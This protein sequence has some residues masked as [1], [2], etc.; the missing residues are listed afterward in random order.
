MIRTETF[1]IT[2]AGGAGVATGSATT[3]SAV[4]GE[5]LGVLLNFHASA[6]ATTDTTLATAGEGNGPAYNIIVVSNSATDA[7]LAVRKVA[8]DV[9]AAAIAASWAP[10][11]VADKLTLSLAG[12]DAL[13]NAVVATVFYDDKRG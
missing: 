10:V 9:A 8:V 11:C 12:C 4:R 7:Y 1:K 3:P 2:T 13:T 6:P 5:I